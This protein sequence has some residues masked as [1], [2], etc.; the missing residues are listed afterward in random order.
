MVKT[1]KFFS[2]GRVKSIFAKSYVWLILLLLYT[3]IMFVIVFSFT[4]SKVMGEWTGFSFELYSRLFTGTNS[5]ALGQA[6]LNTII[7]AVC[8]AV[9]ST[10]LGTLAAIGIYNTRKKLRVAYTT[11]NQIPVLSA[12]IVTALS[13]SLLFVSIGFEKGFFTLLLAHV[14]FCT[15]FV[16]LTV[17][18]KLRQ[19]NPNV[20]EAALDLGATPFQAMRKIIIPQIIPAMITGFLLALTLSVD[21]FVITVFNTSGFTTLSKYIYDDAVK[22]GL[23]PEL[24]ALSSLIFAT[25]MII[26]IIVNIISRKKGSGGS[27]AWRKQGG[28]FAMHPEK[29]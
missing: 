21:D 3:P 8:T 2:K 25:V 5:A 6:V 23:G 10:I 12:E 13:L 28:S 18:P 15:P 1:R 20:Y 11:V 4:E 27:E 14:T 7:L 22:G 24:R 19:L 17:M 9:I 29:R 26:L 16:V